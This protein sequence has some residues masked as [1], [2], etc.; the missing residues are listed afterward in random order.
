MFDWVAFFLDLIPTN[1]VSAMAEQKILQ[2]LLFGILFGGALSAIGEAALPVVAVL[3][4]VQVATM[5]LVRWIIV[6]APIPRA[7]VRIAIEANPGF[8]RST[9]RP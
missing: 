8:L 5:K 2:V 7:R 3:R 1:V 4:G 6:L 9:G